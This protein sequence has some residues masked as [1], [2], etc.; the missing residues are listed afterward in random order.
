MALRLQ[1]LGVG[2]VRQ[3]RGGEM[4]AADRLAR[5]LAGVDRRRIDLEAELAEARGH[6]V[7]AALAIEA[8]VEQALAEQLRA[9]VDAIAEHVQVLVLTVDRGDLGGRHHLHAVER[10]G[11]Q[12]LVH[13][14][15]GVVV[16]ERQQ[17]HAGR[18]RVLHHLGRGERSIG[19]QRVRLEVEKGARQGPRA[20]ST[21]MPCRMVFSVTTRGSMNWSR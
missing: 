15:H 3:H 11:R 20:Y 10:P 19:V 12:R 17:P 18:G 14:V 7:G 13:P 16:G 9:V 4:R 1:P 2:R 21:G 5:R 8:R 6:G